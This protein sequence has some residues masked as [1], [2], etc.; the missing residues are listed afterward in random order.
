MGRIRGVRGWGAAGNAPGPLPGPVTAA[1]AVR[2]LP[3]AAGGPAAVL[4]GGGPPRGGVDVRVAGPDAPVPQPGHDPA[5][6]EGAGPGPE[7]VPRPAV[8]AGHGR[9]RGLVLRGHGRIV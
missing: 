4:G 9:L 2:R 5:A 1:V 6:V 3:V 7:A 8:H